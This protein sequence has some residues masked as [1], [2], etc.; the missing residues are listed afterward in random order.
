MLAI[1]FTAAI[2][3]TYFIVGMAFFKVISFK[4]KFHLRLLLSPSIGLALIL[5]VIFTISKK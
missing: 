3:F 1:L 5:I 4:A 2:I